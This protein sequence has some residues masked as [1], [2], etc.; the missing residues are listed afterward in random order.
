MT[1][2][3][4]NLLIFITVPIL[5]SILGALIINSGYYPNLFARIFS[6][7]IPNRFIIIINGASGVGKTTIA[8][9]ISQRFKVKTVMNIDLIREIFRDNHSGEENPI[10]LSSFE[11]DLDHINDHFRSQCSVLEKP[12]ER[13]IS[14]VTRRRDA[15]IIEGVNVLFSEFLKRHQISDANLFLFITLYID[16]KEEHIKRIDK[17]GEESSEDPAKTQ[18]YTDNIDKIQA[19]EKIIIEDT[20]SVIQSTT[21]QHTFK[22]IVN[23]KKLR[24]IYKEVKQIINGKLKCVK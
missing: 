14:R 20:T 22:I 13:M 21:A 24:T 6:R 23:D 1:M 8:D 12:M 3:P 19:I 2:Q 18:R 10:N 7:R 5:A 16:N 15:V 17:R 4:V 9:W 11:A